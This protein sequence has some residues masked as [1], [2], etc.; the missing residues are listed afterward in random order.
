MKKMNKCLIYLEILCFKPDSN[1][2]DVDIGKHKTNLRKQ[3]S[4]AKRRKPTRS[5][6]RSALLS[7]EEA[8]FQ[9]SSG[10]L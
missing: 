2:L 6:V 5:N 4:L 9:D 3:G 1:H 7:G 10:N 8:M